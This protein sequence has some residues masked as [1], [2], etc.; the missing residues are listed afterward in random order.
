MTSALAWSPSRRVFIRRALINAALT[1]AAFVVLTIFTSPPQAQFLLLGVGLPLV[2]TLILTLE[3]AM[4]WRR[5]RDE[6]WEIDDGNLVHDGPDGRAMIPLADIEGV[7]KRLGGAVMI[8]LKS[9]QRVLMRYL[10]TPGDVV[11]AL[12]TTRP[13]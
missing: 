7:Q 6:Q 4:R 12:N 3:D 9:R 11:T 10:E 13:T 8:R 2:L 5:L 1:F